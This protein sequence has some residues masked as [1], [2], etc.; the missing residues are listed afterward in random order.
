MT[1]PAQAAAPRFAAARKLW[2]MP[3]PKRFWRAKLSI[4]LMFVV[5]TG[6]FISGLIIG[7]GFGSLYIAG[8]ACF[9]LI[10]NWHK[11]ANAHMTQAAWLFGNLFASV[12][13]GIF[14][15]GLCLYYLLL[16]H[17]WRQSYCYIG[18]VT[19]TRGWPGSPDHAPR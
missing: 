2:S 12:I 1:P 8:G 15:G 7:H 3:E 9:Y 4:M 19:L 14:W 10:V 6:L 5:N 13:Y 11:P 18:A 16:P 17:C